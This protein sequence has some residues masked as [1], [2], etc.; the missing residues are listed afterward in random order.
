MPD[1]MPVPPDD[2]SAHP[3]PAEARI[4]A[5]RAFNRFYT[6]RIGVLR[7]RMYGSALSL[8]EVRVLYELAH[9]TRRPP[10][11]WPTSSTSTAA[12]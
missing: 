6:Q 10:A 5:V 12:T 9:R 7:R 4:A 2:R 11:C 8:A 1:S 3:A